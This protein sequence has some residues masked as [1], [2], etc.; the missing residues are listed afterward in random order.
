MDVLRERNDARAAATFVDGVGRDV[1]R[2]PELR[3][4]RRAAKACHFAMDATP[5]QP[6]YASGERLACMLLEADVAFT[7]SVAQ[8]VESVA[9][10]LRSQYLDRARSLILL[11]RARLDAEMTARC[12]LRCRIMA[13]ARGWMSVLLRTSCGCHLRV[14]VAASSL[15]PMKLAFPCLMS[16]WAG[17]S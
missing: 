1:L 16:R 8:E 2:R 11:C 5:S 15:Y 3:A 10:Q 17:A 7:A 9:V 12:V 6:V 14:A 4:L 13:C